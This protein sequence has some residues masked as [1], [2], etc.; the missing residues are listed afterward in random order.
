MTVWPPTSE[1]RKLIMA[2]VRRYRVTMSHDSGRFDVT[3]TATSAQWAKRTACA[4]EGPPLRSAIK[5]KDLGPV[6]TRAVEGIYPG[7]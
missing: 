5:V 1:E 7:Y 2:E 4:A 6:P 3:T